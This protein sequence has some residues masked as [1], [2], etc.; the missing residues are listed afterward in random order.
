MSKVTIEDMKLD[1]P[2]TVLLREIWWE[3]NEA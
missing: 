3:A 1:E 2:S